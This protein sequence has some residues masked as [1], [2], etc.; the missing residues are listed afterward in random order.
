MKAADSVPVRYGSSPNVSWPRPQRGSRKMFM[1]GPK[2]FRCLLRPQQ[3]CH[4]EVSWPS[5]HSR[6]MHSI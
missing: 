6:E 1:F 2:Q 4:Q 5:E 3:A